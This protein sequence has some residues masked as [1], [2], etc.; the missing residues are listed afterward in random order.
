MHCVSD[1]QK[2]HSL[3]DAAMDFKGDLSPTELLH[4]YQSYMFTVMLYL[5]ENIYLMEILA[6]TQPSI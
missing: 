4:W 1:V 6:E 2:G 5:S 3:Q